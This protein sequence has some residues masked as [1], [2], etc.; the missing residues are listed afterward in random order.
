MIFIYKEKTIMTKNEILTELFNS[1]QLQTKLVGIMERHFLPIELKDDI[2]QTTFENLCKYDETKLL[3]AYNDNPKRILALGV[4]VM[5]R[6]CILKDNRYSNP[7]HSLS[8]SM[9]YASS[10]N[11]N[12]IQINPTDSFDETLVIEDMIDDEPKD[13]GI[14]Y[15]EKWYKVNKKLTEY[16]QELLQDIIQGKKVPIKIKRILFN[17]IKQLN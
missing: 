3:D 5:L 11:T 10:L 14:D 12:N 1:N 8:T 15:L 13:H 2:I 7:N 9:M 17:R 16:E 4:T 6:K